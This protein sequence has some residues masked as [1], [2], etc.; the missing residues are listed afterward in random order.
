MG[1]IARIKRH[2]GAGIYMQNDTLADARGVKIAYISGT[3]DQVNKA[4]EILEKMLKS[5]EKGGQK[6]PGLEFLDE[7]DELLDS[8]LPPAPPVPTSSPS[9]ASPSGLMT[10]LPPSLGG[11]GGFRS[12]A[13][14]SGVTSGGGVTSV[15]GGG[16]LPQPVTGREA[17]GSNGVVF[18]T[19]DYFE[20]PRKYLGLFIGKKGENVKRFREQAIKLDAEIQ[21]DQDPQCIHAG[22]VRLLGNSAENLVYLKSE[23][24]QDLFKA[25]SNLDDNN[26][27]HGGGGHGHPHS[28]SHSHRR[29]GNNNNN[30]N[31][32]QNSAA[33]AAAAA[34]QGGA[35]GPL[36]QEFFK[37]YSIAN[38]NHERPSGGINGLLGGLGGPI[39]G[40]VGGGMVGGPYG[41]S[42][43]TNSHSSSRIPPP[44]SVNPHHHHPAAQA[45]TDAAT[46]WLNDL[47]L[48]PGS[49]TTASGA[50]ASTPQPNYDLLQQLL[51][52]GGNLPS[53]NNNF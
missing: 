45:A 52:G 48:S 30:N 27:Q 16:S 46:D 50:S 4:K 31:H 8:V 2:T 26:D 20:V 18:S 42:T 33:A 29:H 21:V 17:V 24:T 40:G 39:R 5:G 22:K 28:H 12:S 37:Q 23:M 49:A 14:L 34:S 47:L 7:P 53:N 35:A 13:P 3:Q 9:S 19:V 15:G 6:L 25:I 36:L 10:H 43:S 32:Q 11:S 44:H 41:N 51:I 38:N 1:T